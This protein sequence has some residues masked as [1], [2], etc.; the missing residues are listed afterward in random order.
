MEHMRTISPLLRL[1]SVNEPSDEKEKDVS[2]KKLINRL[3]YINFCDGSVLINFKHVKYQQIVTIEAKP[4]PCQGDIFECIWNNPIEVDNKLASVKFENMFVVDGQKLIIVRPDVTTITEHGISFMLPETSTEVECRKARRHSCEGIRAQLLQNSA[5]FHGTLLDFSA[6]SFRIEV[7]STPPQTFQWVNPEYPVNV[8]FHDGN[9]TLYSAE[10]TVLKH[11][12]GKKIRSYVLE[13]AVQHIQRFKPKELRSIRQELVPQPS[14]LFRHP[15]SAKIVDLKIIDLSG[16]GFSVY[17]DEENS[18]LLPGMVIP[19]LE[20]NIGNSFSIKC[21]AQVV[22]RHIVASE[23]KSNI[24]KCGI[25][26][27]DMDI[28]DH[29]QLLS[30]NYLAKDGNSSICGKVVMENLWQF[31]FETGFI[32]PQKYTFLQVNKEKLKET[33]Q[34]L[35]TENPGIARHFIYQENGVILGHL[36]MLRYYESSWLI[37][38]HAAN[39]S[40]STN[41]GL[42]VLNQLARSINDSH[43]LYSAHMNYC[44]CYYRPDN[45]FPNRIF[46]NAA[47]VINNRKGCSIDV[48]AYLHYQKPSKERCAVSGP[49]ALTK[50]TPDDLSELASYYEH[51]SGG[52]MLHALDLEPDMLDYVELSQEY[53]RLGFSMKRHIYSIRKDGILTAVVVVNLSDVGL[54]LSDLTNCIQV[55]VLDHEDFPKAALQQML[56]GIS[57][58]FEQN[59]IPV[60]LYPVSYVESQGID[61]DKKY[62]LWALNIP[63]NGAQFFKYMVQLL[64]RGKSANN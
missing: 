12:F 10:C 28:Q 16:S 27:L 55:I 47:N 11:D 29:V 36:A 34:R 6:V 60:L 4:I 21:T 48:F 40:A 62:V 39:K 59:E 26:F 23:E 37:H 22:Y 8:I 45:K 31:F 5:L 24:V 57:D 17:E 54:N 7:T 33:Y 46:G 53:Q 38:H 20:L 9:K 52:L 18:V 41:A 2:R 35:Y 3:N 32:Y 61:Y 43:N 56:A 50:T 64:G 30:L 42:L 63:Q 44:I 14:I 58:Q 13:P 19:E 49:W 1:N 51:E 25:S 15:L